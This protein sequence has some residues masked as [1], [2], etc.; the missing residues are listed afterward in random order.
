MMT[1]PPKTKKPLVMFGYALS[2]ILIVSLGTTIWRYVK[3]AAYIAQPKTVSLQVKPPLVNLDSP[4]GQKRL[5]TS[6][7]AQDFKVLSKHF[8]PQVYLSYCG[9]ATSVMV[10]NALSK[11]SKLTQDNYFENRVHDASAAYRTFFGGMTLAEFAQY[12][13]GDDI[14]VTRIHGDEISLPAFRQRIQ[15]NL[16]NDSDVMV[17]NYSRK[18]LGQ[19]GGGHFSPLY[20][21]HEAS[22]T[23]LIGDVGAHKYP[24]VWAPLESLWQAIRTVDNTSNR[25]RG[26]LEIRRNQIE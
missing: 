26:L 9:V 12:I 2:V 22:D 11:D 25:S 10:L 5:T 20:A 3:R 4:A 17:V 18:S 23:V 8:Q 6:K 15:A 24:P 16:N 21:F 14:H 7:F 1:S 13:Q 19:K